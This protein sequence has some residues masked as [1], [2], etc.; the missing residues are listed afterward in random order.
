M[1]DDE[2]RSLKPPTLFVVGENEVIYPADRAVARIKTVAPAIA[3]E[4]I[5]QA[6]HDLTISQTQAFNGK[7][8]SFL[9]G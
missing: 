2:L 1:T 3:T 8:L 9:L 6:S 5:A 7:V 4:V